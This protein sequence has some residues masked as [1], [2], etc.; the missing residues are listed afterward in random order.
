MITI[1]ELP[2]LRLLISLVIGIVIA[3]FFSYNFNSI[4][5]ICFLGIVCLSAG[6]Y[7]LRVNY[8]W[9]LLSSILQILAGSLVSVFL[10]TFANPFFSAHHISNISLNSDKEL[11]Y[12]VKCTDPATHKNSWQIPFELQ[13]YIDSDEKILK[14]VSGKIVLF[15]KEIQNIPR[16]GEV[17]RIKTKLSDPQT[18]LN[19]GSFDYAAYLKRKGIY[20]TGF[21]SDKDVTK[22][23]DSPWS[24][25]KNF[26]LSLRDNMITRTEKLIGQ[27]EE[28]DVSAGLLF[29]Y[30]DKIDQSTETLFVNTGAVHLLAVSGMHVILIFSNIKGLLRLI[31]LNKLIGEKWTSIFAVILI[32]LFTFLA[33]LAPSIVRATIMI[34]IIVLGDCFR[35]SANSINVVSAG[36][37]IMLVVDPMTLYDIG[38]Q[39]SFAAVIGIIQLQKQVRSWLPAFLHKSKNLTDLIS[40]TVAAQIGTLPL[41][42]FYFH[43]F[44]VY[45]IITGIVAVLISDW[46]IK[47]GCVLLLTSYISFEC[48]SYFSLAWKL[49]VQ[50][51]LKSVEWISLLPGGL[52]QNIYFDLSMACIMSIMILLYIINLYKKIRFINYFA[53]ISFALMFTFDFVS[54]KGNQTSEKVITYESKKGKII[55]IRKGLNTRLIAGEHLTDEEIIATVSPNH[56]EMRIENFEITRLKDNELVNFSINDNNYELYSSK[57][58]GK[59]TLVVVNK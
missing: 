27:N 14:P 6:I 32:W 4:L 34:S 41:I 10:M 26:T 33:G 44:P 49:A 52:I 18:P 56:I 1:H 20:K 3:P 46:I 13:Y 43:Q 11:E 22:I 25:I 36:A 53:L 2:A 28:A 59:L 47:I 55:E 24:N 40:V 17:F 30:R 16:P 39:L 35:K 19:P 51:L 29:G 37:L 50:A 48:A 31:R 21:V 15:S 45:F 8:K 58:D 9:R 5:I 38:F 7:T 23:A 42:L 54:L 12:V 57:I